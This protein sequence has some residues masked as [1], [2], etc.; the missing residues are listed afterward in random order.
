ML[1]GSLV[2]VGFVVGCTSTVPDDSKTSAPPPGA[3]AAVEPPAR[4]LETPPV[5]PEDLSQWA[6]TRDDDCRQTCALGA[7]NAA[8]IEAHPDADDCDDGCGWSQGRLACRDHECVTLT[9]D[10]DIDAACTKKT[11]RRPP[12][13]PR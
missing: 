5:V 10:G 9:A 3:T 2:L 11:P 7:V 4:P 13:T 12:A 1:R 8:W 6:C